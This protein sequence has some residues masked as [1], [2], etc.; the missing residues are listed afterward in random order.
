M[1]SLDSLEKPGH[2]TR[3]HWHL[4]L[5]ALSLSRDSSSSV[6]SS[7]PSCP[8]SAAPGAG[9]RNAA[10]SAVAL[11][12]TPLHTLSGN[13]AGERSSG[14]GAP[15]SPQK[16]SAAEPL[17]LYETAPFSFSYL[18]TGGLGRH[19]ELPGL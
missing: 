7:S 12:R 19:K 9:Q 14:F 16:N 6:S 5:S 1:A 15:A 2:S 3:R 18:P 11:M 13:A 17:S 10:G 4:L 8:A